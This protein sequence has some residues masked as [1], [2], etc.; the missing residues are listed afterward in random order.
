MHSSF[1]AF[2]FRQA[3]FQKEEGRRNGERELERGGREGE[4]DQPC[5]YITMLWS[6]VT[7]QAVINSELPEDML[8]LETQNIS[9]ISLPHCQS[10]IYLWDGSWA[11]GCLGPVPTLI[12]HHANLFN[13]LCMFAFSTAPHLEVEDWAL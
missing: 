8:G 11:L 9:T 7:K 13:Q 12:L 4:R 1:L 5:H 6:N 3:L 2:C 10:Q